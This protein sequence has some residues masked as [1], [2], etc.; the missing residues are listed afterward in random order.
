MLAKDEA[1]KD[2]LSTVLYNLTE[3]ITIGASLLAPLLPETGEKI[4]EQLC[5]QLRD[6]DTLGEFGKY[7]SGNRVTE[8]PEILF[9]RLDAKEI[10]AKAAEIQEKQSREFREHEEKARVNREKAGIS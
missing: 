6:F 10:L 7:P 5:T 2:R 8:K 4:V 3:G 9:A 1:K